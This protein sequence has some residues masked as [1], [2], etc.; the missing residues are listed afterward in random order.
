MAIALFVNQD[1]S[2]SIV[3]RS[4]VDRQLGKFGSLPTQIT[5]FSSLYSLQI[6]S[7]V[8]AASC[9]KDTRGSFIRSKMTRV[10]NWPLSSTPVYVYMVWYLMEHRDN[11]NSDF[12]SAF[13]YS[14]LAW[15][16]LSSLSLH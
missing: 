12:T 8:H 16:L 2:A 4:Q 11:L 9:L 13:I 3:I 7:D 5:D 14:E 1:S 6:S 10:G 15:L